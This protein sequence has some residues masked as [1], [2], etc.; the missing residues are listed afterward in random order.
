MTT[1]IVI[2]AYGGSWHRVLSVFTN[3]LNWFDN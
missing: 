3:V 2:D 1:L